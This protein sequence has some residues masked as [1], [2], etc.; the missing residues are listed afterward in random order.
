M[1][2]ICLVYFEEMKPIIGVFLDSVKEKTKKVH[3]IIT[4]CLNNGEF[5]KEEFLGKITLKKVGYPLDKF[6]FLKNKNIEPRDY[7]HAIGLNKSLKYVTGEYVLFC[8]PDI[9]F[10]TSVDEFYLET[11][12]KYDLFT[13]GVS[14]HW[15]HAL[16]QMYF[17]CF[18]N[19]MIKTENLPPKDY[20]TGKLF[21][22]EGSD[23]I[24]KSKNEGH[25]L[26]NWMIQGY[27][28]ENFPNQSDEAIY[29]VGCNLWLWNEENQGRWLSFQ[30]LDV[31][32]YTTTFH[33][34]NWKC[35]EKF[36][37][38]KL[39]YHLTRGFW[40]AQNPSIVEAYEN[41]YFMHSNN[42]TH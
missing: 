21:A 32:N 36:G 4:V 3:E 22:R 10:Y 31:H 40:N 41:D 2:S 42:Q 15:A 5:Y 29:D 35:K 28:G 12:T 33:K 23:S 17:P 14:H 11:M 9:F 18:F 34:S 19:L 24:H 39:I 7:G 1:V 16:A 27:V 30:T 8:D 6:D 38:N 37:T 26:N 25:P 20:L 13:V